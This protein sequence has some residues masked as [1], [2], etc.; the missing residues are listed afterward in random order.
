MGKNVVWC[1]TDG[2]NTYQIFLA[3]QN[4]LPPTT[5]A[6]AIAMGYSIDGDFNN[7]CKV[8]FLDLA[9]FVSDWLR[10]FDPNDL[11]CERPWE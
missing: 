3:E 4:P 9:L 1:E 11:N 2:Y 10:C 7:D 5:C 8:D 6:E